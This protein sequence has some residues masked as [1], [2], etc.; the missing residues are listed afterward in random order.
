MKPLPA[1]LAVVAVVGAGF[2]APGPLAAEEL[3]DEDLRE[4]F[5]SQRDA[6]RGVE[7]NPA[8]GAT[9]GLVLS[10][11]EPT[12]EPEGAVSLEAAPG[13][14]DGAEAEGGGL[15]LREGQAVA[16]A[17]APE[18]E[19]PVHLWQLPTDQQV[20]LR[21]HF[22]FDSAAL[23]DAEKPNL[24]RLCAIMQEED[25]Q[26]FRII[27]HTDAAGDP[28]YNQNLSELRAQEVK[29]FFV[30]DCGIA[31]ER[32]EAI[33]VGEDYLYNADDPLSGENRRV[34]FQAMS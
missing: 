16:A 8:L 5:R 4:L 19:Q 11:I 12:P 30:D 25:I 22:A 28:R 21:V 10:V 18:A 6:F 7:E 2:S 26:H 33:G 23:A 15:D 13:V 14:E 24:R 3:S 29:R 1:F 34:E 31:T 27:G 9:R 17:G 20:N 32:L